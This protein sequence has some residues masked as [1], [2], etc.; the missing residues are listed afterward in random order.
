LSE[1][2]PPTEDF[3]DLYDN[4]PCGYVSL[5]PDGRVVKVNRT[6]CDWLGQGEDGLLG[7]SVHQ[8]LSF[9]GKIAF[10]THLAPLLRLQGQV[11]EI[12]LDLV[13]AGG[14]RIPVIANAAERR[15]PDGQHLF[16]RLTLFKAVD[17][18]T[19]ERSLIEARIKAEAEAKSEHEATRLREQFIAVLGHDLRNPLAGITAGINMLRRAGAGEREALVLKEMEG[20]I[21]RANALVDNVMDFARG[22]LGQG[23]AIDREPGCSLAPM[24]EQVVA[25]MRTIFPGHEFVTDFDIAHPV[26]CDAGRIGQLASNLLSNAVTHGAADRPIR[27]TARTT[28]DT[29]EIEVANAGPPIPE[30]ARSHLFEPFVRGDF[31]HSQNGLGLGL[32]IVNEVAKAHGGT[33]AVHSDESETRFSLAMP[34]IDARAGLRGLNRLAP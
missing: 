6:L 4:A 13:D 28:E 25:E 1:S 17:R 12:A 26:D 11:H 33:M 9:G 15:G 30:E 24:L 21:R 27:L 10:E 14:E 20:S 3:K 22:K 16:T 7:H 31:S 5:S 2:S 19:F 18:R 29:L 8:M 23:L 34:R 32:F